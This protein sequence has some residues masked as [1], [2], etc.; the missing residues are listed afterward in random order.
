MIAVLD[1][2]SNPDD[3]DFPIPGNDDAARAIQLY[4]ELVADAVLDGLTE[5]QLGAGIDL[6]AME[7]IEE[8]ALDE[9]ALAEIQAA[10]AEDDTVLEAGDAANLEEAQPPE[11]APAE[12]VNIAPTESEGATQTM[13]NVAMIDGVGPTYAAK[14]EGAGYGS[15]TKVAELSDE[16]AKTLDD[17]LKLGGKLSGG[18]WRDQAKAMLGGEA[19]RAKVD[20]KAAADA[21]G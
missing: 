13:D 11:A 5:A 15:L 6:G 3:A 19:P 20:Q 14:L 1:T 17:E 9:A 12:A 21:A 4:C 18:D 8:L 7:E 2:N 10:A 16:D